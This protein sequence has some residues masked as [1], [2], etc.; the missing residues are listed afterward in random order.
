M[1][2]PTP[3][4]ARRARIIL[5]VPA[6]AV[7]VAV[8]G[9]AAV[10]ASPAHL[11]SPAFRAAAS[12]ASFSTHS[13]T[14][15]TSTNKK[16][17]LSVFGGHG[18]GSA[19]AMIDLGLPSGN[20][21]HEWTFESLPASALKL[22]TTGSGS[23]SATLPGGFG[24]LKLT[25]SGHGTTTRNTACATASRPASV[26]GR[27]VFN[28]KSSGSH[29]WGKFGKQIDFGD[30]GSVGW[31]TGTP[32]PSCYQQPQV[33]C[34]STSGYT[35]SLMGN[36]M[37][38]VSVFGSVTPKKATMSVERFVQITSAIM[39][40][41]FMTTTLAKRPTFTKGSTSSTLSINAT[42]TPGAV[43]TGKLMTGAPSESSYAC[44]K[45]NTADTNEWQGEYTPGS[46]PLAGHPQIFGPM[47]AEVGSFGTV[48]ETSVNAQG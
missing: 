10:A 1:T 20:E 46:T 5:A 17:K 19:E 8:P 33:P 30:K 25:I 12:Q 14:V 27:V 23:L 2:R 48:S 24:S 21:S 26:S 44:G 39:R 31:S 22:S 34:P 28:T 41:D 36:S 45:G 35:W 37:Q 9:A 15:T 3:W 42:G 32:D 38:A 16:L 4:R 47:K 18:D 13:V 29:K 11:P 6:V 40:D 7:A 43:G